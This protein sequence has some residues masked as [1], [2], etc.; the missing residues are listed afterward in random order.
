MAITFNNSSGTGYTYSEDT[1]D[2]GT[3]DVPAMS[4]PSDAASGA[5]LIGFWGAGSDLAFSAQ[6]PLLANVASTTEL[7]SQ[8]YEPDQHGE[9]HCLYKHLSSTP[10]NGNWNATPS[11]NRKRVAALLALTGH[12]SGSPIRAYAVATGTSTSITFPDTASVNDGDLVLR[13]AQILK[14]DWSYTFSGTTVGTVIR[15]SVPSTYHDGVFYGYD[16]KSGAGTPGTKTATW[17]GTVRYI[18]ATVVIAASAG[19]GSSEAPPRRVTLLMGP[20]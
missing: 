19:S 14:Q 15:N 17:S 12:D 8:L 6:T 7:F 9:L 16:V 5:L 3:T 10:T 11:A 20:P 18:A 13:F 1:G 4:A 2:T